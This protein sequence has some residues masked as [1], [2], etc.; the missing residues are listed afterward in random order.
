MCIRDSLYRPEFPINLGSTVTNVG[1][2]NTAAAVI[3]ANKD[4]IVAETI[5]FITARF[6]DLVY[7]VN[8]CRRDTRLIIDSIVFDLKAGGEQRT[9]E[10]QGSY[11][12]LGY[13]DF[14]TQLGDSTQE[15]ATEAAIQN[16]SQLCNSLLSA[17][18]PT[19]TIS[20]IIPRNSAPIIIKR[21]EILIKSKI[22]KKT[23]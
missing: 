15:T 6:P 8:K 2:Y 5:Q 7:D 9:L 1:N 4:Y 22:K 21:H 16:I 10:T 13:T 20:I 11:H 19:Y 12:E 17:T 23:E 18:A 3:E 14:L